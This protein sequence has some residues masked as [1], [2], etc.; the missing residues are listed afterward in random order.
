M[1][2]IYVSVRENACIVGCIVSDLHYAP[3]IASQPWVLGN[4][5]N[6]YTVFISHYLTTITVSDQASRN[7]ATR[8][9]NTQRGKNSAR[10]GLQEGLIRNQTA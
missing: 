8:L 3:Q 6:F 2:T 5:S 9:L 7:I 1:N 10:L 4:A